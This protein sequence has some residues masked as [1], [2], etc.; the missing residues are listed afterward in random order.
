VSDI[1][2]YA[3]ATSNRG[4]TAHTRGAILFAVCRGKASEGLDFSDELCRLVVCVGIPYPPLKS[5]E[6]EQKKKFLN[7]KSSQKASLDS[8]T[9]E[10][11]YTQQAFRALNQGIGLKIYQGGCSHR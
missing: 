8:L 1:I 5:V 11:W 10:Q 3:N 2:A 4:L 7:R 9:G 6:V